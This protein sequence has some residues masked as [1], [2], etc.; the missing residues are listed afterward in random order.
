MTPANPPHR[1]V[2]SMMGMKKRPGP[3]GVNKK[4]KSTT[5][6]VSSVP[7]HNCS[8]PPL[9]APAHYGYHPVSQAS[10]NSYTQKLK[11]MGKKK[12]AL[13]LT[14]AIL[15]GISCLSAIILGVLIILGCTKPSFP[16]QNLHLL[17]IQNNNKNTNSSSTETYDIR[18]RVGYFGGCLSVANATTANA[19]ANTTANTTAKDP[20]QTHCLLNLRSHDLN[21]LA[22][23]L[24]EDF[25]FPPNST[26]QTAVEEAVEQMLPLV[27]HVQKNALLP[28][29]PVVATGLFFVSCVVLLVVSTTSTATAENNKR[30]RRRRYKACLL[31]AALLGAGAFGL[32]VTMTVG[33]QQAMGSIV[34]VVNGDG[35]G[36]DDGGGGGEVVVERGVILT[37]LAQL[38]HLEQE[39]GRDRLM[40]DVYGRLCPTM[41]VS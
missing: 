17:E 40:N 23:E 2:P 13:T 16:L 7:C 38:A 22:E 33:V 32:A 15:I 9:P 5:S 6:L 36:L 8:P 41:C 11:G 20:P 28:A 26:T 25:S 3:N 31:V 29:L 39:L 37:K 34:W 24:W 27:I 1:P 30:K 35:D 21:D 18:L 10:K 12:F 14:L 19:T 4:T